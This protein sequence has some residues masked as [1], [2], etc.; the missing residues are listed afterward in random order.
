M[1][2]RRP[3]RPPY[4]AYYRSQRPQQP[5]GQQNAGE[6]ANGEGQPQQP[7]NQQPAGVP[8]T[9]QP[10]PSPS[11]E[12]KV[13]RRVVAEFEKELAQARREKDEANDKYMRALAELDNVRKRAERTA[14]QRLAGQRQSFFSRFLS[15][16][17]NME[18]ALVHGD[19]G[20]PLYAGVELTYKEM[21]RA[22]AENGVER[23]DPTGQEFDPATDEAI[24]AVPMPD[25][26]SGTV[27]EVLRPGYKYGDQILRPAQ[28]RVSL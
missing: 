3:P 26:P 7:Q 18:R 20:D 13:E 1:Y 28:V 25:V 22:L 19:P 27:I 6:G 15:V 9:P 16:V 8:P 17:D 10:P 2:S 12:E 4:G 5:Q 14:E 24:D 11:S 21:L 23:M